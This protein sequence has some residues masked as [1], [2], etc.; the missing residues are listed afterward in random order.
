MTPAPER[1]CRCF[2]T[3]CRVTAGNRSA[4]VE[5]EAGPPVES[6]CSSASR[7]GSP[8]AANRTAACASWRSTRR[9]DM[10]PEPREHLRPPVVVVGEHLRAPREGN[11]VEAGLGHRQPCPAGD[12]LER[13]GYCRARFSRVV[14]GWV[15]G[16]GI[17]LPR[18]TPRRLHL[19]D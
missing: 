18:E 13:K 8:S 9:F 16:A 2:E 1:T 17:P 12:R 6:C 7:V 11:R 5:T 4:R 10:A 14:D 19:H 15:D 3:A